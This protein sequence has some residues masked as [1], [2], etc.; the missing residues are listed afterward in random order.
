MD[1]ALPVAAVGRPPAIANKPLFTLQWTS[2]MHHAE[3]AA[4]WKVSVTT[5]Y[6]T[7]RKFHL[8]L[9]LLRVV[10]QRIPLARTRHAGKWW[11]CG[12]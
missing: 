6:R 12:I 5:I 7:V 8:T 3:L 11:E 4:Y 10:P 1:T 9:R 2:G